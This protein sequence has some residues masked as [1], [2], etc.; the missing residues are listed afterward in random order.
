M[1]IPRAS[2]EEGQ[3]EAATAGYALIDDCH[4]DQ[5]A[6]ANTQREAPAWPN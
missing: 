6:S 1:G 4:V 2:E 3:P 5:P